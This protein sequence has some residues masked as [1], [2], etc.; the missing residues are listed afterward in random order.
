[1]EYTRLLL[2]SIRPAALRFAV[3]Q[4]VYQAGQIVF[5]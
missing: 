3:L 2:N 1:M 5:E 4:H